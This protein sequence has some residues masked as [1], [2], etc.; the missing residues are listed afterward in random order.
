M[1]K[2]SFILSLAFTQ[3]AMASTIDNTKITAILA[4]EVYGNVVILKISPKPTDTPDCQTN[5]NF[6]YG[7]DPTTEIGKVT[8]SMALAAYASAKSVYLNGY[9]DCNLSP[10][11]GVERLRQISVQ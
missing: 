8:L 6:N 10:S 2:I 4:G 5:P 11:L 9:G 7:F 1:K 3:F